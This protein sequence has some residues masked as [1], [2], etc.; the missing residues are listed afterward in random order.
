MIE[1]GFPV[2]VLDDDSILYLK[3]GWSHTKF[4]RQIVCEIVANK[5]GISKN[6]LKNLPYCQR[7]A[8]V[9]RNNFYYGEKIS[10]ELFKKIEKVL[11]MKLKIVHDEHETRCEISVAEFKGLRSLNQ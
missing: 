1:G 6:K 5:Y 10:K 11:E 3:K 9:V 4:W 7:R 8:R 2:Y